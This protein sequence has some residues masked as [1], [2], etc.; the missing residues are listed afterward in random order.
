MARCQ[1][2]KS[3]VTTVK[4]KN[5]TP[6][7]VRMQP[8]LQGTYH[9]A[10][11]AGNRGTSPLIVPNQLY[12]SLKDTVPIILK[13]TTAVEGGVP[14][15]ATSE[16]NFLK[17]LDVIPA[18]ISLLQLVMVCPHLLKELTSWSKGTQTLHKNGRQ[19][20]KEPLG[21]LEDVETIFGGLSYTLTYVVLQ[22]EDDAVY[23]V[24]IGRPW[25]YGTNAVT[26]WSKSEMNATLELRTIRYGEKT[27]PGDELALS[28][29]I[30][31]YE[32]NEAEIAAF[33]EEVR[34]LFISGLEVV[35][36]TSKPTSP[37]KEV[38][39]TT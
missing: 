16:Y 17:D 29:Y 8:S 26:D 22:P 3:C 38:D 36:A 24:L 13:L 5:I 11:T 2:E 6:T 31:C 34:T 9:C 28:F 27:K 20:P 37:D 7:R 35:K 23:E 39:L 30:E 1:L 25:I 4:K 18:H 14:L 15:A 21:M 19:S 33:D 10:K 32:A 12:L